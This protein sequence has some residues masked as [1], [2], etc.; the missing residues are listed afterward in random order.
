MHDKRV[1]LT[2]ASRGIGRETALALGRLGADLSL[3]VRDR[4]RGEAVA[5][6]VGALGAGG[7]VRVFVGDLSS[8]AE[9][10]RVGE[11]LASAHDRVD[12]LVNNAGALLMDRQVTKDGYEATFA[13]NHLAYFLLTK[14][15][16]DRVKASPNGR[17]VNVAS[18]AHR[19]GALDLD[20]LMSTRGYSGFRV[21]S[22][23][24]LANILFTSELARRLGASHVTTNS[25]HP[26]VIAS[27][28]A[29]NNGGVVGL[30]ARLAAPFLMSSA[31]GCKTTVFL[32]TDPSVATTSGKYF[33]DSKEKK[34]SRAAR[35]ESTARRLW[36]ASEELVAKHA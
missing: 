36:E 9:V 11:E 4:A 19:R 5:A 8:M 28:F 31:D 23:S 25:L 35:D 16:L 27:G 13:T 18:E 17:I 6:E 34:P 29:R 32:A 10:K 26:G 2:G 24:K 21:Y 33:D 1:V 7:D 14:I 20:D 22:T 30:L 15:L 12:V 3:V